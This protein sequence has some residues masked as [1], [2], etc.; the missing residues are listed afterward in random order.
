MRGQVTISAA[1]TTLRIANVRRLA[2]VIIA[3]IARAVMRHDVFG[4][5]RRLTL[6]TVIVDGSSVYSRRNCSP[7]I[8]TSSRGRSRAI[9][10]RHRLRA[11]RPV[12]A[13][14]L[15]EARSHARRRAH[16]RGV[17]R[18]QVYE[19]QVTSVI[20]E[21][22][23]G[24]FG[25][26]L[27]EIGARLENTRPLRKEDVAQALRAMRQIAGLAVTATTRR[28]PDVRNAF[29]LV[30]QAD[31][32]PIDGVVR[33]NNR[34]TDQVG[35]AFMLGQVFANGLLGRQEKIGLIFAAATDHD[36]YLGGGLYV[37]TALGRAAAA[38]TP[39]SSGRIRRPTKRPSI[40]T[41]NTRASASR[42]RLEAVPAGL[43]VVAASAAWVSK[44]MT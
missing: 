30:V 21:G 2:L 39:C 31:F 27:D 13:R 38:A 40:S 4:R 23:G 41:M 18:L 1:A 26:A 43:G 34:G 42:S 7:S 44:P 36:E 6:T 33:M 29:E 10:A 11:T 25:D 17:L 14:R 24:R 32:S 19:A 37:D 8:A 15:R 22:D 16:A 5:A 9:D 12:R 3:G 35:P 20:F 28:D